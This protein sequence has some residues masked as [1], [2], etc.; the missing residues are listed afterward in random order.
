MC[1]P[2]Q[3]KEEREDKQGLSRQTSSISWVPMTQQTLHRGACCFLW[4]MSAHSSLSIPLNSTCRHRFHRNL[5]LLEIQRLYVLLAQSCSSGGLFSAAPRQGAG[6]RVGT[7]SE[8]AG[9]GVM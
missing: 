8:L 2:E 5:I 3:N 1:H 4:G 6:H 9:T 7:V